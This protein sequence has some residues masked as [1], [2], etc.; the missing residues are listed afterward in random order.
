MSKELDAKLMESHGWARTGRGNLRLNMLT[1]SIPLEDGRLEVTISTNAVDRHG[2][3]MEPG[4]ADWSA[5]LGNPVVLWAHD[6]TQLP[7]A[8]AVSLSTDGDSLKAII[9]WAPTEFALQVS[10]LYAEKFLSAWSIGFR[11]LEWT[12]IEE[13]DEDGASKVTGYHFTKWELLEFSAVPV[14]ANPQALGNAI[15]SGIVTNKSLLQSLTRRMKATGEEVPDAQPKPGWTD[16]EMKALLEEY[17]AKE[18]RVLSKRNRDMLSNC[19]R[20][21]SEACD[22]I[23]ELLDAT[24]PDAESDEDKALDDD[25]GAMDIIIVGP[26]EAESKPK[27]EAQPK[28]EATDS[29]T[30]VESG[31]EAKPDA[32]S[33]KALAGRVDAVDCVQLVNAIQQGVADALARQLDRKP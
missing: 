20:Q 19:A 31:T 23:R 27:V 12:Q 4:G 25:D 33:D 1:K 6:Y 9:E 10:Q 5:F 14:P 11:P 7:I 21:M 26:C 22:A 29:N 2:D 15:A 17:D 28:P 18:G 30:A 16:A 32:E 13:K 8:R 24:D 3:I